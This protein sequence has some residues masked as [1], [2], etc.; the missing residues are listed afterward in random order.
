MPREITQEAATL[1]QPFASPGSFR[2]H[3]LRIKVSPWRRQVLTLVQLQTQGLRSA[4]LLLRACSICGS[5]FSSSAPS[6]L[7][8]GPPP[9]APGGLSVAFLYGKS[10]LSCHLCPSSGPFSR[11]QGTNS[12]LTRALAYTSSQRS[13]E[14][15]L[16]AHTASSSSPCL[17][18]PGRG[19]LGGPLSSLERGQ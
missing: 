16:G 4:G 6:P 10:A 13:K 11:G 5:P 9:R 3:L 1:G 18:L 19:V 15:A 12:Q 17:A 2:P 7:P 14:L 8:L